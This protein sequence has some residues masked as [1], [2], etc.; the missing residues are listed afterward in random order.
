MNVKAILLGLL[1]LDFAGLTIY[2]FVTQDMFAFLGEMLQSAWGI[3]VVAEI[4][5]AV[6][7]AAV[8][9]YQD[10]RKR[11]INP[12]PFIILTFCLGITGPL[13]YLFRL[14]FEKKEKALPQVA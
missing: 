3:Q 2:A 11:G 6:T 1:M 9:T 12:M 7:F 8:W 4:L 10:A 13:A 14:Q 5:I